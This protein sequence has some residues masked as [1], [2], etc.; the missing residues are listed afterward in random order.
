MSASYSSELAELVKQELATG[1]YGS[2]EEL[3]L[4]AVRSLQERDAWHDEF[5]RNL[6][7]RL[8]RLDRGEGIELDD[9]DALKQFFEDVKSRGRQRLEAHKGGS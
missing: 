3:L 6:R 8:D 7:R 2:E 1:K 4:A 5:R 9:E